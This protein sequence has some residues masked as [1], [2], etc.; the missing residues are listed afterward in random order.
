[1][2]T[3]STRA[4]AAADRLDF[5]R[6]LPIFVIVFV[7]LLA[8][9][10]IIPL[11]PLYAA[12]Y[13]A[14]PFVIGLLG[15]TYPVMQFIA[16]PLLGRLSDRFG[17]KPVLVLSLLGSTIG[18]VIMGLAR[19]VEV[20]F[21]ARFIDGISGANISTAQAAITDSTTEKTRTQGLGLIGAAFGIGFTIGP[22][23]AFVTLAL[24]GNNYNAV[25][26]VAAGFAALAL[27]LTAVWFKETLP[28]ERRGQAKGA[29]A[30][31][32]AAMLAALRRPT[33]G[34]LLALIFAQQMVFGGFEQLLSLFTLNRLGLDARGNSALFVII[35]VVVVVVQGGLIGRWSRR[36][37]D[38]W[39]IVSGL[40][41][42]AIG[43]ILLAVTPAQPAPWYSREAVV[44]QLT[45]GAS[46]R[47]L[48]GETPPTQPL[49][50]SLPDEADRSWVGIAWALAAMLIASVGGAVLSPAIN[51]TITRL[52][53]SSDVGGTLGISAAFVS[54]A[55]ALAPVVGGALFNWFGSTAPFLVAGIATAVLWA[56]ASRL[57]PQPPRRGEPTTAAAQTASPSRTTAEAT[58]SG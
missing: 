33:V 6:I 21:L 37:G 3:A 55:N 31:T 48:P 5:K 38:R 23:L 58:R 42:L 34:F 39:L 35:G 28:A 7:D 49:S 1:M 43:M 8:L 9:T 24:S 4:Q 18:F 36:F 50:V 51:S 57:L 10:I 54:A 44:L 46:E 53:P 27:L 40:A 22:V 14:D 41:A 15:A 11:L 52:V 26:F 45:G 17:R 30:F 13:G 29:P 20:L 16:A 12:S 2:N 25:A 56:M 47:T 19:S 32:P